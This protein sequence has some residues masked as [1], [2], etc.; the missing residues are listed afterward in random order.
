MKK[1][2]TLGEFKEAIRTLHKLN[3]SYRQIQTLLEISGYQRPSL[4]FLSKILGKKNRRIKRI[5]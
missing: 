3:R 5:L 4:G 2:L 1:E